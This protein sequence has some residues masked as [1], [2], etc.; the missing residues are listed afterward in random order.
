MKKILITLAILSAL[1]CAGSTYNACAIQGVTYPMV[2]GKYLLFLSHEGH[3]IVMPKDQ[4]AFALDHQE[5]GDDKCCI[6]YHWTKV[7]KQENPL[8]PSKI[9]CKHH[10][11]ELLMVLEPDAERIVLPEAS[12]V[13][14]P[15]KKNN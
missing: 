4:F 8:E 12:A 13:I 9:S 14:Q 11:R 5:W 6:V 1:L 7:Q 10:P 3:E 2:Q 15:A